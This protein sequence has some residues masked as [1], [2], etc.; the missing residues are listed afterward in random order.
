MKLSKKSQRNTWPTCSSLFHPILCPRSSWCSSR[1]HRY[2]SLLRIQ[3]STLRDQ[4]S[5][6]CTVS[7]RGRRSRLKDESKI[8]I[9][10]YHLF[11]RYDYAEFKICLLCDW[12]RARARSQKHSVYCHFVVILNRSPRHTLHVLCNQTLEIILTVKC[13]QCSQ[14]FIIQINNPNNVCHAANLPTKGK[15]HEDFVSCHVPT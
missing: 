5:V 11:G 15:K 14:L 3:W 2:Q 12:A 13:K 8:I 10:H 7:C 4:G 1:E 9:Y 6:A